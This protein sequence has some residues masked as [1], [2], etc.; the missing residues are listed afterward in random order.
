METTQPNQEE[1]QNELLNQTSNN[2][3]LFRKD[4]LKDKIY[5][6]DLK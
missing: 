2:E 4:S 1:K 6:I 5:Q 3:P